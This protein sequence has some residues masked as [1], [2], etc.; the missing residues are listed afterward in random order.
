MLLKHY[1]IN[2]KYLK[3]YK[4]N[5]IINCAKTGIIIKEN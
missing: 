5:F 2:K 4:S 3:V 1:K